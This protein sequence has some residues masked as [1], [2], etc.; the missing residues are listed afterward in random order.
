MTDLSDAKALI[1]AGQGVQAQALLERASQAGNGDATHLLA[2]LGARG[3]WTVQDWPRAFE[4]LELAAQQGSAEAIAELRLIGPTDDHGRLMLTPQR[5]VLC[6]SPR[7]RRIEGFLP[8]EVCHWLIE[9]V[10][11]RLAPAPVFYRTE[12][13]AEAETRVSSVRTN[14]ACVM[15]GFEGGV[16]MALIAERIAM[17]AGVPLVVLEPPQVLHYAVGQEFRPHADYLQDDGGSQRIATFLV[18]LSEDFEG[19]ETWF[20][21]A[22]LKARASTGGAVY[23]ANVDRANRP[24]PMS[25][26]AGLPPTRGEKWLLSQWIR[27]RPFVG[28]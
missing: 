5:E 15:S 3:A 7:V 12:G 25:M 14:R 18:Y 26:H 6:E 24:D 9:R 17:V 28:D 11:D 27:D 19:G 16:L 4:L 8:A 2:T 20:P 1:D 13:R 21:H 10:R 22:E 23:F